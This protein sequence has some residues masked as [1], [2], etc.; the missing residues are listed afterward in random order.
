MQP[1]DLIG[2][3]YWLLAFALAAVTGAILLWMGRPAICACGE[4][5][6]WV[7]TVNGPDN[8]QHLEQARGMNM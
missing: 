4:V 8:S 2:R 6:L 1:V 5:E 7:G 3:R